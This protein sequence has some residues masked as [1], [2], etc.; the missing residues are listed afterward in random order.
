M[1]RGGRLCRHFLV[2]GDASADGSSDECSRTP[3]SIGQPVIAPRPFDPQS[4]CR[5]RRSPP[6][7]PHFPPGCLVLFLSCYSP[8]LRWPP[9]R[10][11]THCCPN[12]PKDICRLP[13]PR[14][15]T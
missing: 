4:A 11:A 12:R 5:V 1:I 6:C 14:S 9:C 8:R 2:L 10:P 15:S 13:V 3:A 7:R